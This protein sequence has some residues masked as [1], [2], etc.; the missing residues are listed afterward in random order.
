[1]LLVR[2][3]ADPVPREGLLG[4]DGRGSSGAVG[5]LTRGQYDG[6][7]C[8]VN[9]EEYAQYLLWLEGALVREPSTPLR[10]R[11]PRPVVNEQNIPPVPIA[12]TA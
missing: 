2:C 5:Y 11:I 8:D 1:M 4:R 10:A 3:T 7:V 6:P 12:D 9:E